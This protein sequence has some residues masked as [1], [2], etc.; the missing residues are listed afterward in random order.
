MT[1]QPPSKAGL[2]QPPDKEHSASLAAERGVTPLIAR[3][4]VSG[5]S[6][7]CVP[8]QNYSLWPPLSRLQ[9]LFSVLHSGS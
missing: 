9:A 7:R 1:A 2:L 4:V 3:L 5:G 6:P 8:M